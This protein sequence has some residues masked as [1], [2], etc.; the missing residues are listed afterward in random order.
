MTSRLRSGIGF[1]AV[2]AAVGGCVKGGTGATAPRVNEN[3]VV[4]GDSTPEHPVVVVVDE[5]LSWAHAPV[6]ATLAERLVFRQLYQNLVGV[7]CQGRIVAGI[8]ESWESSGD[9]IWTFRLRPGVFYSDGTAVTAGTVRDDWRAGG[10]AV[11]GGVTLTV[12]S[13]GPFELRVNFGGPRP[14]ALYLLAG[15]AFAIARAAAGEPAPLGTSGFRITENTRR[16]VT[17]SRDAA[18]GVREITYRLTFGADLRDLLDA[19]AD[20]LVTDQDEVLDYARTLPAYSVRPLPWDRAY[21]LVLTGASRAGGP[22][23]PMPD[24]PPFLEHLAGEAIRSDARAHRGPEWWDRT[25]CPVRA[26]PPNAPRIPRLGLVAGDRT[27]WDIAERLIFLAGSGDPLPEALTPLRRRVSAATFPDRAALVRAARNRPTAF[28]TWLE[29]D[30]PEFCD[31]LA[32]LDPG[33]MAA[34]I[35]LVDTRRR[36]VVRDGAPPLVIAGDGVPF[37]KSTP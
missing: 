5:D 16:S 32:E 3:C 2:L 24:L 10:A 13:V 4:P 34:V 28:I 26:R 12:D 19:G 37:I 35:P 7:D 30:T 1:L 17:L 14:L 29:T 6:P 22:I 25:G 8:A 9:S 18:G 11:P 21:F 31:A 23:D 36:L 20:F 27:S 33:G 15:P